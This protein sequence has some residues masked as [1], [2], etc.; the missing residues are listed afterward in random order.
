MAY[1]LGAILGA[2]NGNANMGIN[3]M[4]EWTMHQKDAHIELMT[5]KIVGVN[6]STRF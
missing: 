3:G 4:E 1:R 2:K 5:K 6:E